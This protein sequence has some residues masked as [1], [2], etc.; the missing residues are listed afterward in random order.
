MKTM[1]KQIQIK[2]E[3]L[4]EAEDLDFTAEKEIWNSYKLSDGS[5][6]KLKLVLRGVKRLKMCNP[7]GIPIYMTNTI[8]VTRAVNVP[9]KLRAKPKLNVTYRV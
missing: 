2:P 6:L 5:T 4:A 7:D 9:K 3:D 8:T 1:S